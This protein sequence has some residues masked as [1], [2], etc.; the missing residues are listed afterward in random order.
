MTG[1]ASQFGVDIAEVP[2]LVRTAA[3]HRGVRIRGAHFYSISNASSEEGLSTELRGSIRAALWL[4]DQGLPLEVLD[5]GGGFAAPYARPGHPVG[6][7]A[8]GEALVAELDAGL[9][10]W[11]D[12]RPQLAVE[13]GRYLVAGAGTLLTTVLDIKESYGSRFA[14]LDAGINQLGGLSGLR[15]LL[16]MSAQPAEAVADP[17]S[18]PVSLA[19]PLC[20]PLDMLGRGLGLP[21][22][23]VGDVLTIP[24]VGA[25]GLTA[26]LLGFL[27]H[28]VAAE[29]VVAGGR[30]RS[31]SRVEL[32]RTPLPD[33]DGGGHPE[34]PAVR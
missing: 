30:V 31:A 11:R 6:Y 7:P 32:R 27:G 34:P 10:G 9:D 20:T 21:D 22:V 5:I 12:G 16:P 8:L 2:A 33:R 4:R 14:V 25:Y 24:N 15:R 26:S 29:V 23:T 17:G 28:P 13:S 3:E 18:T 1:T 19:G